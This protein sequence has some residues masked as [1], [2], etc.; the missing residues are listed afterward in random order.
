MEIVALAL[1]GAVAAACCLYVSRD[2]RRYAIFALVAYFLCIHTHE[3]Y[4][5]LAPLLMAAFYLRR[6]PG[7]GLDWLLLASPVLLVAGNVLFKEFVLKIHFLTGT[8]GQHVDVHKT[9]ILSFL[10]AGISSILGFDVGPA[11]LSAIDFRAL[12]PVGFVPV[13]LVV[14]GLLG[15]VVAAWREVS[16]SLRMSALAVI[17]LGVLLFSAS[18]T[19][20]QEYRW[21]YAA[22]L[23]LLGFSAA[24][25]GGVVTQVRR[26][27]AFGGLALVM[28]GTAAA[29]LVARYHATNIFF[30]GWLVNSESARSVIIEGT[31]PQ[32]GQRPI[33]LIDHS[34][35][36]LL[37]EQ[38]APGVKITVLPLPSTALDRLTAN[39][40]REGLFYT[41]S[42]GLWHQVHITPPEGEVPA[43]SA[44]TATAATTKT[45]HSL[46]RVVERTT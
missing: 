40:I 30:M 15:L 46:C 14:I 35:S 10:G 7:W 37:F 41:V 11:Y 33:Y 25:A 5:A 38:Y 24:M 23:A 43:E 22:E 26:R 31:G 39:E 3:R 1:A 9:E 2:R 27:L 36:P 4:L 16:L 45:T 8:G 42:K 18:V 13:A 34:I 6:R 17:T 20:R 19:F 12:G 44:D 28:V 29:N 21:L 32:L